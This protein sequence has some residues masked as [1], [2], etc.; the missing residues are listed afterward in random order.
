MRFCRL[1]KDIPQTTVHTFMA[2]QGRLPQNLANHKQVPCDMN[3]IVYIMP[4]I[5]YMICH[6]EAILDCRCTQVLPWE[7][8]HE[9]AA[10]TSQARYLIKAVGTYIS[11]EDHTSFD[12]LYDSNFNPNYF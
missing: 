2:S 5:R 6:T 12:N 3:R 10:T 8:L 1:A 11:N 7:Q 4:I 9:D